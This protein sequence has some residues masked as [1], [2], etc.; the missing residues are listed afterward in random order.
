MVPELDNLD[1]N[2]LI[3]LLFN[4]EKWEIRAEAA[5]QIGLISDGRA[6]NLLHRALNKENDDWCYSGSHLHPR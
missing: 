2:N 6:T 4:D 5:R 3:K 1:Y